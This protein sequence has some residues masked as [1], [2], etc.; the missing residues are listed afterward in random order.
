[1]AQ[2]GPKRVFLFFALDKKDTTSFSPANVEPVGLGRL[3]TATYPYHKEDDVMTQ[4]TSVPKNQ[5]PQA[6]EQR[7]RDYR[8][9]NPGKWMPW[10][11]V[12]QAVGGSERDFSKMMRDA[13][14]K[15]TTD[16]AA[17]AAPPDLPEE[18]RE[19]FDLFRARIWGKACDIADV[20][21]TAERLVRQMDNAKLAQ[22]RVEHDELVAQ[23]VR[24]R[25]RVCA[26]T[27][28]L[29][30]VNVDQADELARTKSQLRETRAALDEMRDLF[31]QLTQHA[32]Q[33]DDAPDPSRAPQANVSMSRTSPLPG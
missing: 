5:R 2:F 29:K 20:N 9:K 8:R 11:N 3:P 33:Q 26:E 14:E 1:M 19:E 28:N 24:E 17:L 13:K 12:L 25:D 21:A 30:Q 15:I 18:L 32:P 7:L 4:N 10:R 16:E 6:V 27:E 22:E 23:I 31:T